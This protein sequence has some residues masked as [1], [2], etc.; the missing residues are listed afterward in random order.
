MVAMPHGTSQRIFVLWQTYTVTDNNF[1]SWVASI[2][3]QIPH[4]PVGLVG[5]LGTSSVAF[6]INGELEIPN[7]TTLKWYVVRNPNEL[8]MSKI[9][10]KQ[11][12]SLFNS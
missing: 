11:V 2:T 10:R 3:R 6:S 12:E 8:L 5:L 7:Y 1:M 9:H 4:V